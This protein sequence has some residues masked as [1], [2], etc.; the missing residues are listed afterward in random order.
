MGPY[1]EGEEGRGKLEREFVS[2]TM[3]SLSGLENSA[4]WGLL[5]SQGL[6]YLCLA[7]VGCSFTEYA[8]TGSK[9]NLKICLLCYNLK[10]V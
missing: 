9:W 3:R 4:A 8:K 2:S 10:I 5:Q 6:F 7:D 1:T